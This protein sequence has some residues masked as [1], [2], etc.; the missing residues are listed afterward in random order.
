M[1]LRVAVFFNIEQAVD[2]TQHP[3]FSYKLRNQNFSFRIIKL[4][5]YFHSN[6]K[7]MFSVEG[8]VSMAREIKVWVPQDFVLFA[9]NVY[10]ND[11]HLNTRHQYAR[12]MPMTA[13]TVVLWE[14]CNTFS[15]PEGHGVTSGTL[16][17]KNIRPKPPVLLL[18]TNIPFVKRQMS[19]C[20]LWGGRGGER[21]TRRI[22]TEKI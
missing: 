19:R 12:S 15:C 9:Y 13:K 18:R 22:H 17:S 3:C 11:V 14:N 20:N 21:I 16:K 8:E 4:I 7:C 10:I 1:C 2:I 5:I 6:G